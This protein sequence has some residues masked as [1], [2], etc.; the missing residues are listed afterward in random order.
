MIAYFKGKSLVSRLIRWRTWG[1]YSH[2]AWIEPDGTIWESW[3][4][5]GKGAK[6]NGV[7][8]GVAGDLHKPGT[9]V[10]LYAIELSDDQHA[11]LVAWLEWWAANPDASYDF[12]GVVAGFMLRK[13]SEH[14]NTRQFC[15]EVLMRCLRSVRFSLLINILPEQTAPM[16]MA[17][18]PAQRFLGSWETGTPL[19]EI[20]LLEGER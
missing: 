10:D 19:P 5:K 11:D 2:V 18:S 12:K 17:H 6:R 20:E 14:S 15:S 1:V 4:R 13:R 16:D 7:R 3:H 9:M 8:R